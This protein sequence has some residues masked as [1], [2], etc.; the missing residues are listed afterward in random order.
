MGIKAELISQL[1]GFGNRKQKLVAEHFRS[2]GFTQSANGMI[3]SPF[4]YKWFSDYQQGSTDFPQLTTFPA[5]NHIV[6]GAS[7]NTFTSGSSTPFPV[8]Y[9]LDNDGN[10]SQSKD[11]N[12]SPELIYPQFNSSHFGTGFCGGLVVDQ[13]GRTLFPGR[14]YLGM[15]DSTSAPT[16]HTVTLTNGAKTVIRTSGDSFIAGHVRRFLIISSGS[17][18]YFYRIATFTDA[19]NLLLTPNFDLASGS[20]TAE[21]H[22]WDDRW[23]DFGALISTSTPEGNDAY[24][25]TET[26]EDTVLFGRKNLITT[27][28][29]VTDTITTDALPAFT[30]P[31]GFQILAIHRGN[32]GILM[33]YNFQGKG[34]LILWDNYSTRSI[35]PWIPLPDR[36]ISLCKNNGEWVAITARD[37][38][39]TNGYSLTPLNNK[40]LDTDIDPLALQ[41]LPNTSLV[42]END[43]YFIANFSFNGK[44]RG[45]LHRMNLTTKLIEY[46]PRAD[47]SQK[48]AKVRTLFYGSTPNRMYVGQDDSLGYIDHSSQTATPTF[49]SNAVGIGDNIKYAEAV[50]LNIGVSPAYSTLLDNPFSFELAVKICPINQQTFTYGQVK[51]LQTVATEIVV[52][53]TTF[54]VAEVGD[55]IEF[56]SGTNAGYSRNITGR[57]GSGATVTYTLDRALPFLSLANDYFFRTKFQLVRAKTFTNI[58]KISPK[59]LYFNIK[60][61]VEGKQFMIKVDIED[62][63]IPLELRPFYFIYDDSGVI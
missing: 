45:G 33:G 36:L 32:N 59:D 61:K 7:R 24:I 42:I 15:F 58:T 18:K 53:E 57:S 10:I 28:N 48:D 1:E 14:Q 29:T 49:I 38:F 40:Y 20:Y 43:L 62:A 5:I 6:N 8:L 41:Q 46:I 31:T 11:G 35:A 37:I 60:N 26:Y 30:M 13:K 16:S 27:L 51:T 34:Y 4:V 54:G 25:P 17:N 39:S 55:E 52:N 22:A 3:A 9:F 63:T 21:I 2:A 12:I 50:K 23:K 56:I 47:F 44:R 19:N